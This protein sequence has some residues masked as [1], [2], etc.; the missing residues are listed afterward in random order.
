[1]G[2]NSE[3]QDLHSRSRKEK[4]TSTSDF[5]FIKLLGDRAKF[6]NMK[7]AERNA[8]NADFVR[9]LGR[10]LLDA[11]LLCEG[12]SLIKPAD[13]FQQDLSLLLGECV[14][15][16]IFRSVSKALSIFKGIVH[17]VSLADNNDEI[18]CALPNQWLVD[19]FRFSNRDA[20]LSPSSSVLFTFSVRLPFPL[21]QQVVF[22]V[23]ELLR[24]AALPVSVQMSNLFENWS[25][26]AK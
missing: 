16:K 23:S 24:R 8:F 18:C 9:L 6:R 19:A 2:D 14:K 11:Q 1:M 25:R 26:Q 4:N 5:F 17:V 3:I 12:D 7:K 10:T 21:P 13:K 22:S 15:R 20:T